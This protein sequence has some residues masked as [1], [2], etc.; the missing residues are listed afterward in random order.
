MTLIRKIFKSFTLLILFICLIISLIYFLLVYRPENII[1][2]AN[3]VLNDNYFLEF[4]SIESEYRFLSPTITLK[5]FLII[6]KEKKEII[7][8]DE[9]NLDIKILKSLTKRYIHL[10]NFSLKNIRIIDDIKSENSKRIYKLKINNIFI[11]SN[12]AIFS[13]KETTLLNTNGNLSISNRIGYVN[14]IPYKEVS[15]FK[16]IESPLYF[17]SANFELNEDDLEKEELVDLNQFSEKDINLNLVSKGYFDTAGQ[18]IISINKYFFFDTKLV[19]QSGFEINDID[20]ILYTNMDEK[21]SGV[22]SADISDQRIDGSI[23]ADNKNIS[24]RSKI[25][26][27]MKSIFN[28]GQYLELNGEEEFAVKIDINEIASLEL[29]SNLE[30]TLIRSNINDLNKDLET[31]LETTILIS[32]MSKP[33]YYIENKKFKT[34]IDKNN[35]GYFA[36]GSL[37]NDDID[38][39]ENQDG[40]YI[41]LSLKELNIDS[42]FSSNQTENNSNLKSI[43]LKVDKLN[44][45]DN[46]FFNQN[47]EINLL[48]KETVA[49]FSGKNLNGSM[50][51]DSS[52]FIRVDVF[53]TKFD[54]QGVDTLNQYDSSKKN[55]INLRFVGKNVKAFDDVFKKIDFYLLKNEKIT[56]F[57]N[58][59]ISSTNFN[60][61]PFQDNEKAYISFNNKNDLYK[62]RG[63][64]EI[65]NKNNA[66]RNL[67]NYNFGY[68]YTDLN[69]QWVSLKELKDLEGQ[70]KFKIKDL[71]SKTSLPDS[72]FLRA[73]KIL[74]LNSII[75]NLNN[76]SNLGSSN[77]IINRAEGDL[78]I[79]KNR[80][81]ISKP[82][83]LETA[84]AK[85]N[86]SG[87]VI[88]NTNGLLDELDLDLEMR[89]KVSENI[90]WY[91]AIF[92]GIPALAGGFVFENII[93]ERLDDVSTFQ[94]DVIGSINDPKIIRLDKS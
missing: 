40:F 70:I 62:I 39:I 45:F 90:P 18:E 12:D 1:S 22:F 83:K 48:P 31:N 5:D 76:D 93:D 4:E 77:L 84:E 71:E 68:L 15:I 13:S 47:F 6:N 87:E 27:D 58:I 11:S 69:V 35:N 55:N 78:Y 2:V 94:F 21:L 30:N 8:I 85:M 19:T 79:G 67:I 26:L 88:K 23:K 86:W 50:R 61:K 52:G 53:D 54:F 43:K 28:Y 33:T 25:K 81:L 89:L 34:F 60:I 82:I 7:S 59:N 56:T 16:K 91:A 3:K 80:A 24:L 64:Y 65:N 38:R 14:N 74:N 46:I 49:S 20:G 29:T 66:F 72:A 36:F 9:V 75:G 32:D 17:Y 44:F 37:F 51:I 73:L 92:G 63:S 57:D 41:F 42:L 10:D